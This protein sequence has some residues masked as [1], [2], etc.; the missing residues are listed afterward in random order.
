MAK[1][2]DTIVRYNVL[3][4]SHDLG[5]DKEHVIVRQ[6]YEGDKSVPKQATSVPWIA[7]EYINADIREL[8]KDGAGCRYSNKLL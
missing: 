2:Y 1:G 4:V 6:Q 8:M 5:K 7:N 3:W